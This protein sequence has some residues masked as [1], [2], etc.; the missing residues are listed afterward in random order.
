[1]TNG[2]GTKGNKPTPYGSA[3]DLPSYQELAQQIRS[4]KLLTRVF[5]RGQRSQ[6]IKVEEDLNDLIQVVDDFYERLGERNWIFHDILNVEKIKRLLA[7]TSD[8]ESAEQ[9]LIELYRD[10]EATKF[11]IMRLQAQDGLR[12]RLHQI[13]R[14]RDHYDAGEFDS[15]TLQL[16]AVVDG[17]VND[18]EPEARKGLHTRN[19]D[20]MAAW[21][22]VV[23]HHMGLTHVMKTFTKTIK[24]RVDDE[25]FELYRH[26][27]VHGA[28]VRFDNVVV[29]TKAWN[30]LFAVSDWATATRKAAEPKE[31]EPTLSEIVSTAK[32]IATYKR[33]QESFATSTLKASDAEFSSDKIVQLASE[34]LEAWANKRWGLVAKFMPSALKGARSEGEAARQA[35]DIFSQFEL[36]EWSIDSVTYDQASSAAIHAQSTVAGNKRRMQFRMIFWNS[37]GNVGI[38]GVDEGTWTV[39]VWAPRTYFEDAD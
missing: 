27:I 37:E 7:E 29:A 5:A 12:Q 1:M 16:I 4:A 24:K 11:W 13:R 20:E 10:E 3:K 9:G 36:E 35:G 17:F 25:V 19:P 8:A 14:A 30:L 22:S 15:C 26:G 39:A 33:Y 34:F 6:F 23:G 28:V 32:R 38:P 31:P 21:D 2:S 18:F